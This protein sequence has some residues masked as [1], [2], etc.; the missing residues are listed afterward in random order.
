MRNYDD[1]IDRVTVRCPFCEKLFL[2][3]RPLFKSERD[4]TACPACRAEAKANTQKMAGN[5]GHDG[6]KATP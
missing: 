3:P 5:W 2:M 4:T 1:T 6:R